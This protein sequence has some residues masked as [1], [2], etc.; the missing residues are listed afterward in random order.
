M[1]CVGRPEWGEND[2]ARRFVNLK[3]EYY[4]E[5]ADALE[6]D[7]VWGLADNVTIGQLAGIV[8]EVDGHGRIKIESKESARARGVPSPDRAE[9]LMLA[10]CSPPQKFEYY[11]A[12][13]PPGPPQRLVRDLADDDDDDYRIPRSRL[14]DAWAPGRLAPFLRRRGGVW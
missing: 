10:V 1:A 13:N 11:P 7:E 14:L 6:R 2:P 9:A 5:L 3:A 8:Y 12:R 4:H